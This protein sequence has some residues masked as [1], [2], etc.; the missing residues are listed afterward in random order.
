[1]LAME[2]SNYEDTLYVS[3]SS[4]VE[5]EPAERQ[6]VLFCFYVACFLINQLELKQVLV[7]LVGCHD[8]LLNA[9]LEN[10]G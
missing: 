10:S 5:S 4:I 3:T 9:H 7:H 8:I 2:E 6:G 1:M